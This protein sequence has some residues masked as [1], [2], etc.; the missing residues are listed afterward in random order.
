MEKEKRLS[1]LVGSITAVLGLYIGS[2]LGFDLGTKIQALREQTAFNEFVTSDTYVETFA[3]RLVMGNVVDAFN[4]M[5]FTTV[6]KVEKELDDNGLKIVRVNDT[7][8][9]K[10][11]L[12]Y[13]AYLLSDGG[14]DLNEVSNTS[15]EMATQLNNEINSLGYII[16]KEGA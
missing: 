4:L 1:I 11:F 15:A 3:E 12:N 16:V 14:M 8:N 9:S 6:D 7:V 5:T 10:N 13:V 2:Q